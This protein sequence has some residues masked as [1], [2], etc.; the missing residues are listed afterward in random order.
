MTPIWYRRWAL[1]IL[2]WL[3]DWVGTRLERL[4]PPTRV[5]PK[6]EAAFADV[7]PYLL[8]VRRH[9]HNVKAAFPRKS[10]EELRHEA[11]A[12]LAKHGMTTRRAAFAIEL[13]MQ[14]W[15]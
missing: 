12:I 10:S 14:E 11:L 7:A 4:E 3:R 5:T 13:V 9:M 6:V 1:A 15:M 8:E 2:H